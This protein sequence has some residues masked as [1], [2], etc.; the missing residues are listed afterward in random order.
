MIVEAERRV[1]AEKTTYLVLVKL[2]VPESSLAAKSLL[3]L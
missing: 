2:S 3:I 1:T